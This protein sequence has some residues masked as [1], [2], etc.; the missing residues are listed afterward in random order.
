MLTTK[1]FKYYL[2]LVNR[3]KEVLN[4]LNVPY[5]KHINFDYFKS[6]RSWGVCETLPH[7]K[8]QIKVSER[9]IQSHKDK[10]VMDTII[11]ELLHTIP[12]GQCHTGN[13]KKYAEYVNSKTEFN[14]KRRT[15]EEEKGFK[16]TPFTYKYKLVCNNCGATSYY[17]KETRLIKNS[18]AGYRCTCTKCHNKAFTAYTAEDKM[19]FK[20]F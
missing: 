5:S 1:D 11:H 6:K 13:W 2:E 9:L 20:I 8:F 15:S 3:S 18:G 10:E 12:G 7:N 4:D 19:L 16:P 17:R 14:I